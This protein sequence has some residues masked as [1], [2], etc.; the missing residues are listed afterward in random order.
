MYLQHTI[1]F[2]MCNVL[3]FGSN[4]EPKFSLSFTFSLKRFMTMVP[5]PE[6][7]F[8]LSFTFS[9]KRFM[10]MVPGPGPEK[11]VSELIPNYIFHC[12]SLHWV[13]DFPAVS[14]NH[15]RF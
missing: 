12:I 7:K 10:T 4:S 6:P 11:L 9:L 13:S 3:W 14:L 1:I 15:L 5:G 8:S 2:K